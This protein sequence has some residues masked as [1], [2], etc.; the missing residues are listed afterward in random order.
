MVWRYKFLVLTMM[1][2]VCQHIQMAVSQNLIPNGGFEQYQNC[3][4][5]L[6][7]VFQSTGWINPSLGQPDFFHMCSS[8]SASVPVNNNGYQLAHSDSGY[9]GIYIYNVGDL[10]EYIEVQMNS[11]LQQ[12]VCYY[13][14]MYINLGDYYK[15]TC[16]TIGAYF[17]DTLVSMPSWY[18]NFPFVPQI[19]N[20]NPAFPDTASWQLVS[21][22]FT[23]QGGE[24]FV[25]IGNFNTNANSNVMVVNPSGA[26]LCVVQIDD[27]SLT[28]CSSTG[29][30]ELSTEVIKLW[31]QI[32]DDFLEITCSDNPAQQKMLKLY[33]VA[34]RM[35][36]RKAFASSGKIQ[37]PQLNSGSYIYE[38]SFDNAVRGRGK[39]IK[40]R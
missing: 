1:L 26:S 9:A 2:V 33:D 29:N 27:I 23:A 3:P 7:Q 22:S 13:F 8:T 25:I 16:N 31:P 10:R 20:S 35:V 28:P 14:E 11:P 36:F 38:V 24:Q 32:F 12:G 30:S 21:G 4:F 18:Y 37:L 6:G 17:S 19:Q 5:N 34:G 15:Y 40:N 39:L